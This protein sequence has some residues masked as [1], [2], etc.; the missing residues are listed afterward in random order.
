M[1]TAT[2]YQLC[3]LNFYHRLLILDTHRS[4]FEFGSNCVMQDR[5]G[6]WG[7]EK[8]SWNYIFLY[9]VS[10][11]TEE[12]NNRNSSTNKTCL[13]LPSSSQTPQ[14]PASQINIW[15]KTDKANFPSA[16]ATSKNSFDILW[17]L[18][19]KL[20]ERLRCHERDVGIVIWRRWPLQTHPETLEHLENPLVSD[21]Q[22]GWEKVSDLSDTQ[23]CGLLPVRGYEAGITH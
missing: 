10:I 7:G 9:G 20:F 3:L 22:P 12:A 6:G 13:Q 21:W 1:G 19:E 18:R 5:E 8:K 15:N 17:T 23:M 4:Y 14:T 16:E 11:Q 2:I